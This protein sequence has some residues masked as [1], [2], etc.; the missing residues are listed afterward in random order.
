MINAGFN[1]LQEMAKKTGKSVGE[2]KEEM[3]KDAI[4]ADMVADAFASA[5]AEGGQFYG[6]WKPSPKPLAA[7]CRPCRMG[8][9]A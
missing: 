2:L 6:R 3:E 8:S 7:R 4:S 5:T 1:P 9:R